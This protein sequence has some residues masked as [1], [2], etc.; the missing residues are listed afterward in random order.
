MT[1]ATKPPTP[2]PHRSTRVILLSTGVVLLLALIVGAILVVGDAVG[3]KR[4]DAS[5]RY[6]I[7]QRFNSIRIVADAANITVRYA[8]I[9]SAK[10]NFHQGSQVRSATL[11]H[12]VTDNV[13]KVTESSSGSSPFSWITADS[14][15]LEIVLPNS[16]QSARLDVNT[17]VQAGNVKISGRFATIDVASNAGDITLIGGARSLNLQALS[18]NVTATRYNLDGPITSVASAGDSTLDFSTPP[19]RANL[20]TGAG[21][22][23][24]T[25]PNATYDVSA[26]SRA[27]TVQ[28]S[29][30]S[31]PGASRSYT[32]RVDAG[33]ITVALR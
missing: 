11:R 13:L 32:L 20:F 21:N 12:T 2:P 18:G 29:V 17:A 33:N 31:T 5:A 28:Q 9:D 23:V 4:S 6:S 24:L 1:G 15:T 22:I 16:D 27:G 8:S 30:T 25:L 3:V 7:T 26:Q 10:V 19:S 14:T